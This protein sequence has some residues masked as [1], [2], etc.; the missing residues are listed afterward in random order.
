MK[1]H[2]SVAA[3][4]QHTR[5]IHR[6][7]GFHNF[8]AAATLR[9]QKII[10]PTAPHSPPDVGQCRQSRRAVSRFHRNYYFRAARVFQASAL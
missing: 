6:W 2:I 9:A 8:G 5:L 7:T 3:G 4:Q 1:P 10:C